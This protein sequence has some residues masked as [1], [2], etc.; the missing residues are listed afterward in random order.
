MAQSRYTT[1]AIV[2]HWTMAILLISQIIGGVYMHKLPNSANE[3]FD[4]YQLHKS[5]GLSILILSVVRLGW[6]FS[7]KATAL[8]ADMANWERLAARSIQW[9]FYGLML[10][11]PLIGWA[12]VSVS[13]KDIP[14]F[15]FGVIP[16]P[17]LPLA[18][19][20]SDR[21]AAEGLAAEFHEYLAF[22]F[23]GLIALHIGAALKHRFIAKDGVFASM[24]LRQGKE[25][26]GVAAIMAFL[27]MA[28]G[29]Y[30]IAKAATPP[31]A[32]QQAMAVTAPGEKTGDWIVDETQSTI[33]FIATEGNREIVGAFTDYDVA[34]ILD[35]E[36]LT[37]ASISATI[38]T[39]SA[40][41]GDSIT[42]ET[43]P[44]AQ[45]FDVNDHPAA[46]FTSNDIRRLDGNKYVAAGTLSIKTYENAL[47]L[48]FTLTI[49]NDTA[50]ARA[51]VELIRT[52]YGLG[53][54][55]SWL[56]ENNVGLAVRVEIEI[57]ATRAG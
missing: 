14:T 31:Q 22:L 49:E 9:A 15:L 34:I 1:I 50:R 35:P 37:A 16:W 46:T 30:F 2:L 52:D 41:T 12:M 17:H 5:F 3:K 10:I 56:S 42:D 51:S 39:R 11:I 38:L 33:R 28:S 43:L 18:G 53:L 13:P 40:T 27:F 44:E 6:R 24:A 4:L 47:A 54:D 25:W 19:I 36:D 23:A 7:H 45:W 26:L 55:D 57:V 21:A 32:P 20:V 29:V 48:P 8:P